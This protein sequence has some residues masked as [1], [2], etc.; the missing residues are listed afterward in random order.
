MLLPYSRKKT[1]FFSK[2]HGKFQRFFIISFFILCF[3]PCLCQ[4]ESELSLESSP[5]SEEMILFQEIPSVYSASKYE[6]KVTEA[7]SSVTII[8][9]DEIKKY[10]YLNFAEI[11]RSYV[12]SILPMTEIIIILG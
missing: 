7:P 4:A 3:S 12:D 6:Q 11:L 10:G 2:V 5:I 9:A 8:T 1:I